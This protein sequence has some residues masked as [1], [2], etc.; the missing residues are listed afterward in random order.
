MFAMAIAVQIVQNVAYILLALGDVPLINDGELALKRCATLIAIGKSL[1]MRMR[2]FQLDQL[3]MA[4]RPLTN[5][6]AMRP[7]GFQA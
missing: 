6:Q 3:V 5:P 2:E 1:M 7:E 4:L